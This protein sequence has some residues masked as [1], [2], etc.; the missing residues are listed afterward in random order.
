M[1]E[2]TLY[3]IINNFVLSFLVTFLIKLLDR[4]FLFLTCFFD[5]VFYNDSNKSFCDKKTI[6]TPLQILLVFLTFIIAN[7]GAYLFSDGELRIVGFIA[8]LVGVV[9]GYLIS[10]THISDFLL[11]L[12]CLP[13]E[14]LVKLYRNLYLKILRRFNTKYNE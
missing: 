7:L 12:L 14:A 5:R 11:K 3:L 8:I 1:N 2:N 10:K 6:S 4:Y 9:L 13:I